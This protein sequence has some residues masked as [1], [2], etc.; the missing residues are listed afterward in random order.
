MIVESLEAT[1]EQ[2]AAATGFRFH[3]LAQ[4]VVVTAQPDNLKSVLDDES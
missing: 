2:F 1:A 4:P 3:L